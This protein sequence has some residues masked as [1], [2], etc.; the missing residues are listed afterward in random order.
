[1]KILGKNGYVRDVQDGDIMELCMHP[2][3]V[4]LRHSQYLGWENYQEHVV[5]TFN[6]S[7]RSLSFCFS[8]DSLVGCLGVHESPH[9]RVGGVWALGTKS[10]LDILKFKGGMKKSYGNLKSI[11]G[12]YEF[13]KIS[14][15]HFDW[16]FGED[17]DILVN[18]VEN[19]NK[20]GI[21]WLKFLG[22]EITPKDKKF[23][24]VTFYKNGRRSTY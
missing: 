24:Q 3:E 22:A 15:D 1:M 2:R 21:R 8:D 9:E 14:K 5:S 17:F 13:M 23:S 12:A 18:I 4:D 11:L 7:V 6:S 10:S 19:K 20:L 16:L